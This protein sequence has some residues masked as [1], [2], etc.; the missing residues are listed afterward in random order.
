MTWNLTVSY[1]PRSQSHYWLLTCNKET[2]WPVCHFIHGAELQSSCWSHDCG[3]VFPGVGCAI[4]SA[5]W[6]N[7]RGLLLCHEAS[8]PDPALLA[9]GRATATWRQMAPMVGSSC[10]PQ[11]GMTGGPLHWG[12]TTEVWI[13]L[14]CTIATISYFYFYY[15]LSK[16]SACCWCVSQFVMLIICCLVWL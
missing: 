14:L 9:L 13:N 16:I 15:I 4:S 2:V 3:T 6:M 8:P 5:I 1:S 11:D 7:R 12:F 10:L